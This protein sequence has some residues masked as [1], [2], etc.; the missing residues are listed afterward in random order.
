MNLARISKKTPH[1]DSRQTLNAIHED[2]MRSF[3][4]MRDGLPDKEKNLENLISLYN[5]DTFS[6]D[7][8]SL[9]DD[10]VKLQKDV[11]NIRDNK[12]EFEYLI[13]AAPFL[14]KYCQ[15]EDNIQT[16]PKDVEPVDIDEGICQTEDDNC[17]TGDEYYGSDE[18]ETDEGESDDDSPK[19]P[20]PDMSKLSTFVKQEQMSNKGEICEEYIRVCLYGK[21]GDYKHN[22]DDLLDCECGGVRTIILKE[23]IATCTTCGSSVTYQDDMSHPQYREEV[24][25]LS[26][27]ALIFA[28]KS[29][30]L[31]IF[32]YC[33]QVNSF[34]LLNFSF[35]RKRHMLV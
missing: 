6:G 3:Q 1:A 33:L 32:R 15:T 35:G 20:D 17:Q 13:K 25:I 23:A 7:P 14:M 22:I 30:I 19:Q 18:G 11:G 28:L 10:I 12:D 9:Y 29:M 24:E 4:E 5:S 26:P 2:K 21:K 31:Q 34:R 8:F 16:S 27:F